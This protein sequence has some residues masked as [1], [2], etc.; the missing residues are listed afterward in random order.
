MSN[1]RQN[2]APTFA[3][4]A[5]GTPKST[6][7]PNANKD[8]TPATNFQF[9][10]PTEENNYSTEMLEMLKGKKSQESYWKSTFF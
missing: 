9:R 2:N 8:R 1:Y 7:T 4:I 6:S 3:G 10:Q 5:K